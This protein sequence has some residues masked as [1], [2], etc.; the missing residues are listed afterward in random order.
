MRFSVQMRSP[1]EMARCHSKSLNISME[2]NELNM[3]ECKGMNCRS[4]C[5]TKKD[6][7]PKHDN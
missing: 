4:M 5:V 2:A 7:E 3:M 6:T 1:K